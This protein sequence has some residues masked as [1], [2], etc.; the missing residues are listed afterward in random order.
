MTHV[1]SVHQITRRRSICIGLIVAL[2]FLST[3]VAADRQ[4]NTRLLKLSAATHS[5]ANYEASLA[6]TAQPRQST[7]QVKAKAKRAISALLLAV[8]KSCKNRQ[9]G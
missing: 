9:C 1:S 2:S 6:N 7:A 4:V 3:P 5:T 8:Q